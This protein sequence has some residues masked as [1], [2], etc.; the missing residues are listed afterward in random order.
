M[1]Y[2]D[3]GADYL[4]DFVTG[5][6]KEVHLNEVLV[7]NPILSL[8]N[9]RV[10]HTRRRSPNSKPIDTGVIWRVWFGSFLG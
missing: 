1:L 3:N 6:G 5:K 4:S 10:R 8:T 2:A 7:D 9:T